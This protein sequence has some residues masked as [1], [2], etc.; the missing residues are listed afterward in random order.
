MNK[1]KELTENVLNVCK[2]WTE[3][4]ECELG[5]WEKPCQQMPCYFLCRNIQLAIQSA[6]NYLENR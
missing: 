5:E 6:I 4:F 1:N 2:K 3:N